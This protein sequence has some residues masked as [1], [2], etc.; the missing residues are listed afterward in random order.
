[1]PFFLSLWPGCNLARL[2]QNTRT[3]TKTKATKKEQTRHVL[4]ATTFYYT[5]SFTYFV[6]VHLRTQEK[7]PHAAFVS[8]SPQKWPPMALLCKCFLHFLSISLHFGEVYHFI[9]IALSLFSCH[10]AFFHRL[11]S[12]TTNWI[13]SFIKTKILF[14][15]SLSPSIFNWYF[16]LLS[17][18]LNQSKNK[19]HNVCFKLCIMCPSF[20]SWVIPYEKK[21][22]T[23]KS[24]FAE[25]TTTKIKN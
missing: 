23:Q 11:K 22:Q 18:I 4:Y 14:F 3:H 12:H 9:L 21:K 13:I 24:P 20:F 6:F 17:L 15:L 1:V 19:S 5:F 2:T 10:S 16:L 8:S 25:N 7:E